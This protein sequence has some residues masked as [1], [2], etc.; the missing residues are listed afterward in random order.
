MRVLA[1]APDSEL[2]RVRR[3]LAVPASNNFFIMD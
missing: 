1:S 3:A 2:A